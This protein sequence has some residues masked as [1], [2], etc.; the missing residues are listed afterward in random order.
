M[1]MGEVLDVCLAA[2]GDAGPWN[3]GATDY[4]ARSYPDAEHR[5]PI[6]VAI[7]DRFGQQLQAPIDLRAQQWWWSSGGDEVTGRPRPRSE[8]E[9]VYSNGEFTWA[10]EWTVSD[11]PS[12]VHQGLLPGW[13]FGN[14]A[15]R[16]SVEVDPAA[17][18]YRIDRPEDWVALV[19][20]FPKVASREHSGWEL[21]GVNSRREPDRVGLESLSGGRARRS[22]IQGHLLPDWRAVAA[23][24]DGVH[25]SWAGFL[26]TEGYISDL[27][28]GEVTM[29]RY[30]SSER[31]HWL[32][33][34]F[35]ERTPLPTPHLSG[36][37]F[38]YDHGG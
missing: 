6:A 12:E 32:N 29:L 27:P 2:A 34:V 20:R 3:P 5:R 36:R 22:H 31:T 17:R 1:S 9:H 28:G 19:E 8:F 37:R 30:W 18:V 15:V 24:F 26:T 10:G 16:W 14:A 13:D 23:H 38:A 11:P 33:D 7:A 35:G 25:L 4:L 21:P